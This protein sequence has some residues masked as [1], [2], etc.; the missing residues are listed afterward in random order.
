MEW[1]IYGS[2]ILA[3]LLVFLIISDLVKRAKERRRKSEKLEAESAKRYN[4]KVLFNTDEKKRAVS[5]ADYLKMDEL[6]LE[7]EAEKRVREEYAPQIKIEVVRVKSECMIPDVD[8]TTLDT[9]YLTGHKKEDF[10]KYN[11]ELMQNLIS[12]A[13][14]AERMRNQR[15]SGKLQELELIEKELDISGGMSSPEEVQNEINKYLADMEAQLKEIQRANNYSEPKNS[16]TAAEI[17]KREEVGGAELSDEANDEVLSKLAELAS[18]S[19]SNPPTAESVKKPEVA[20]VKEEK[21]KKSKL[22]DR[23]ER[24]EKPKKIEKSEKLERAEQ[25]DKSEKPSFFQSISSTKKSVKREDESVHSVVERMSAMFKQ[26]LA[27]NSELSRARFD[28]D[29]TQEKI[30]RIEKELLELNV[31]YKEL[32]EAYYSMKN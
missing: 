5:D 24:A 22:F 4:K 26:I 17:F 16:Q 2:I 32:S 7:A 6:D 11:E 30:D 25:T 1:I 21:P 15:A 12:Q 9:S 28:D 19:P 14:M 18:F 27:K 31:E 10:L 13:R 20:E 23:S 8:T 29:V 3:V